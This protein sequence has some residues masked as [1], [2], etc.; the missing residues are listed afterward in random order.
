MIATSF[1][2]PFTVNYIA[3]YFTVIKYLP[4]IKPTCHAYTVVK[5]S[6]RYQIHLERNSKMSLAPR[7]PA[8]SQPG[9]G[10]STPGQ[11]AEEA[12]GYLLLTIGGVSATQIYAGNATTLARG[13]M[14]YVRLQ[15]NPPFSHSK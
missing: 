4:S 8:G 2:T 3:V 14:R 10:R 11:T 6:F 9:S 5:S 1:P 12:N 7:S 13:E 15:S